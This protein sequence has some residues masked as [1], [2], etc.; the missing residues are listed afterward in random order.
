[1]PRKKKQPIV[2]KSLNEFYTEEQRKEIES[3]KKHEHHRK[4]QEQIEAEIFEHLKEHTKK[5]LK[6]EEEK[7]EREKK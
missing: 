6:R 7:K 4:S 1:M 2:H 5:V 3:H